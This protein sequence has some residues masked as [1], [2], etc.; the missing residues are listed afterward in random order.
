MCV[1]CVGRSLGVAEHQQSGKP[2]CVWG[3]VHL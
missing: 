2:V 1:M 3:G